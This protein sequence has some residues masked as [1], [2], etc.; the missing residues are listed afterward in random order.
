VDPEIRYVRRYLMVLVTL[1]A[2]GAAA[3]LMFINPI[4]SAMPP[5]LAAMGRLNYVLYTPLVIAVLLFWLYYYLRPITQLADHLAQSTAPPLE[6]ASRA[7]RLAFMVPLRFL[8]IPPLA[9]AVVATT[10]DILG[11]F[12]IQGYYFSRHF[13]ST[14]LTVLAAMCASLVISILAR[15]ILVNVLVV[16]ADYELED[17]QD[18]R[19]AIR[20]RQFITSV[21]LTLLVSGFLGV[22]GYHLIVSSVREGL[23]SKYALLG[24]SISDDLAIYLDDASLLA[25]VSDLKMNGE[26]YA[27]IVDKQGMA[28]GGG[29]PAFATQ[30]DTTTLHLGVQ[31]LFNGEALVVP[32]ARHPEGWQ[33]VFVYQIDPLMLPLVRTVIWVYGFFVLGIL[34]LSFLVNYYVADDLT[35]DIKYVTYRLKQLAQETGP[36]LDKLNVFSQDEVGDL[37]RAFNALL[38]K[39]AAEQSQLERERRELV[40]LQHVSSTLGSI[41]DVDQLLQGL[42]RNVEETFGYRNSVI[43]LLDP[44]RGDLYIAARAAYIDSVSIE[45]RLQVGEG[46]IGRVA[47]TGEPSSVPNVQACEG[48]IPVDDTTCSDLAVPMVASG[49]LIGVFNVEA[50]QLDAFTERDV[51]ILSAVATQ[52]AIAIHNAQLYRE[53]EEQR[54]QVTSLARLAQLLVST[55]D[56]DEVFDLAL[57][58]IAEI[59]EY[60]SAS[61]MLT[62]DSETITI[63]AARGFR[64]PEAVVGKSFSPNE[65]NL[66]YQVMRSGKVRMVADVQR[67]P[68]WGSKRDDVE[69]AGKIRAWIGVPLV[70]QGQSIGLLTLDKHEPNFYTSVDVKGAETFGAYIAAALH[71]ARL[72]RTAQRRADEL[73]LMAHSIAED[74]SKLDAILFNIA[75]GLIVTDPQDHILLVNPAFESMFERSASTLIGQ[76]LS[77]I[78]ARSELRELIHNTLDVPDSTFMAEIP[79]SKDCIFKASSAAIVDRD[80]LI[81][82]VTIL[83]DVTHEKEIDWMKTEFIS[84]VSHELRTPLTSVLGFAKLI[85]R[86]FERDVFPALSDGEHNVQR[87]A[88]RIYDNLAIILTEGERLTDLI[89]DVLDIAKME[90]GKIEWQDHP[91]ELPVLIERALERRRVQAQQK[92]L[93]LLFDPPAAPLPPIVADPVRIRQVLDNLLSNAIKFTAEGQVR[94]SIRLLA[95]GEE[96][97]GWQTPARGGVL[98]TVADT[99]SGIVEQD[100]LRIFRRFQQ[101]ATDTLTEKPKGTGLGLAICQ[102][103][104]AH[105]KGAIW[106]DSVLGEGSRFNFTLP[107][108]PAMRIV[109]EAPSIAVEARP[110]GL[111]GPLP[112][113]EEVLPLVLIVDDEASIR[114]LLAQELSQVGYQ[115]I[116]ASTGAEALMMARSHRPALILLDIMMP[117]LSG[118]D[119]LRVLKSDTLTANIPILV[120]S[121]IEDRPLGLS[122]G[123][124]AYLT[125]PVDTEHLLTAIAALLAR[126]PQRLPLIASLEQHSAMELITRALGQQGFEVVQGYDPRG[127]LLDSDVPLEDTAVVQEMLAQ[128]YTDGDVVRA[129]R[130]HDSTQNRTIVVLLG[131]TSPAG[132]RLEVMR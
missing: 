20:T 54:L 88:R 130:F 77:A 10:A 132:E 1:S 43:F 106:V 4:V 59:I 34:G 21:I 76:P 62:E 51:R 75:D 121:I 38:D 42:I 129:Y 17:N 16:T 101:L 35:R 7:R 81:G 85:H 104:V 95:P 96:L 40:A 13:P 94:V 117:D 127:A 31:P 55:L 74:K 82:V 73:A 91:F 61:I 84:T 103:I 12:F 18:L 50:Q 45:T 53:A 114:S 102:E 108:E 19:F 6:L 46:I 126:A 64:D 90:A 122:L 110:R 111:T 69:G 36:Q 72:Y 29:L 120:L 87:A 15:R 47:A 123:A 125:K 48:Y 14:I 60:D 100:R 89:N 24:R 109:E 65:K 33:L 118:F 119:V 30:F 56:L 80:R 52:A 78:V 92:G 39:I 28:L 26:G 107:I 86:T 23:R 63:V 79:F 98:V 41:L 115:I 105:Y 57:A 32:I 83:R 66:G 71:N 37:V 131:E 11:H 70:V 9:V 93:T 5:E 25:Y 124:D 128:L 67:E 112:P 116:T 97:H 58:Q 3:L 113:L 49:K 8:Y 44:E 68:I 27:F 22:I 2:V 99:G